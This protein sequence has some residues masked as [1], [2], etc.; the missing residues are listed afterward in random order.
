M[1]IEKTILNLI[2][3]ICERKIKALTYSVSE[4]GDFAGGH[5]ISNKFR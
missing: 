2:Y 1:F 4:N 5:K 3:K